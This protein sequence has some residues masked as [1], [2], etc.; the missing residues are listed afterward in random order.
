MPEHSLR[1]AVRTPEG[2]STDIWKVWTT[3]GTGR[4]DV[5]MTS[6][7]LGHALKLSLHA[8]QWH[9]GF[10]SNKR[11]QLF[12]PETLPPTRF[13][14]KWHR[15][16][17]DHE[18]TVLAARV[19]FPWSSPSVAEE[20]APIDTVWIDSAPEGLSVEVPLFL[21]GVE[22][23]LDDWPGK[24]TMGTSLVGN[25]PLE[26]GG[27]VCVVYRKEA[28]MPKI[29]SMSGAPNFF[30]EK[31]RADLKTANRIVVW[32]EEPDGSIS[33]VEARLEVKGS[34]AA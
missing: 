15:P 3:V 19:C 21:M 5:Y 16:D 11:D 30:R 6:R 12:S 24:A 8:D 10:D 17:I 22:G 13:L 28:A 33:F 23:S 14:G 20:R 31:S 32:G 9:V 34:S 4:R 2:L 29:P 1:F 26:G 7:P 25:L 18:P 27:R